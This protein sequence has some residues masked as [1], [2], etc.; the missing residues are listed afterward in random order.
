MPVPGRDRAVAL[1]SHTEVAQHAMRVGAGDEMTDAVEFARA[2]RPA[3]A[4]E[5]ARMRHEAR[6]WLAGLDI[7]QEARERV[8]TAVAEAVENAVEHAYP[9]DAEGTV[10]LT[11][12]CEKDAVNVRVTDHGRWSENAEPAAPGSHA[13]RGRGFVLMQ[14]SVDSVAIRHTDRGTTVA[15]RQHREPAS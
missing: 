4:D 13:R 15:L 14:R 12:W 7:D 5:A 3:R 8:L 9:G 6:D 10:E 11:L 2:V 1:R